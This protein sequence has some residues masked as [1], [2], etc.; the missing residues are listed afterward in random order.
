MLTNVAKLETK[1]TDTRGEKPVER[2]F[3]FFLDQDSPIEHAKQAL[4]QF[5]GYI[6]QIEEKVKAAQAEA[7]AKAAEAPAE[8][9]VEPIPT[10]EA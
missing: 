1:I 3:H 9:K 8:A 2:A 4:M 10:P 7:A 6:A 5:L